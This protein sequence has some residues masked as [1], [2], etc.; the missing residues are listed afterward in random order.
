MTEHDS[1]MDDAVN[2]P[3][4]RIVSFEDEDGEVLELA[5]LIAF[6]LDGAEYAAL[7]PAQ[8]LGDEALDL[9]V[10]ASGERD[11]QPFFEAIEDDELAQRVFSL[12]VELLEGDPGEE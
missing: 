10:F 11:G 9:F 6:E 7:A 5:L 4:M 12:A 1:P 3:G 2:D 8:Q